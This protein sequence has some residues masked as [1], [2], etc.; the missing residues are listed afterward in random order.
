MKYGPGEVSRTKKVGT[1]NALVFLV[2]ISFSSKDGLRA[3]TKSLSHVYFVP[4]VV[5][6]PGS[7]KAGTSGNS[8]GGIGMRHST[9]RH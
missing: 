7:K 3:L 6:G 4:S 9:W 2:D 1:A 8:D 5:V